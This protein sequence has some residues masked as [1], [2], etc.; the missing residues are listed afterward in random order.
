[1]A[2][3]KSLQADAILTAPI[4]RATGGVPETRRASNVHSV[5]QNPFRRSATA[6]RR[7]TAIPQN[8][9]RLF[10]KVLEAEMRLGSCSHGREDSKLFAEY[11]CETF[12]IASTISQRTI[13]PCVSAHD[14]FRAA[15]TTDVSTF[16]T[17]ARRP[18]S[19]RFLTRRRV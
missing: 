6:Y 2:S 18:A 10:T 9:K 12:S 14:F 13:S 15:L 7:A 5:E 17:V 16:H 3:R 8:V 11:T 1:K 19:L 4:R